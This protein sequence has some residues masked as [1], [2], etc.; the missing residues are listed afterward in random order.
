M[1]QFGSAAPDASTNTN[2]LFFVDTNAGSV[3]FN[4]DQSGSWAVVVDASLLSEGE[5]ILTARP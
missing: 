3:Y 4:V 5:K 2:S 1:A